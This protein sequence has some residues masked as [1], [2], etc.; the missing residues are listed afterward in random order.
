[1][2]KLTAR[3]YDGQTSAQQLVEVIFDDTGKVRVSG[4]SID[5]YYEIAEVNSLPRIGRLPP[6]LVF[7]D[8]VVCELDDH[9]Q[10]EAALRRL[11]RRSWQ[12]VIHRIENN[13]WAILL[14]LVLAVFIMLAVI[15]YGIPLGAKSVAYQIP[16]EMEQHMGEEALAVFDK[17]LCKPSKLDEATRRRL[18]TRFM[19]AVA[20]M[21]APR[22]QLEFRDCGNMGAN[23]FALPSGIIVFTDAMVKL[24]KNDR[25]LIGVLAHEVGHVENRHIMRQ[26]LQNSVTGLLLV[27]L[28]G[29]IGSASSLAAAVPTLLVQAKFSRAFETEA[30]DYAARFLQSQGIPPRQ[31]ANLLQRLAEQSGEQESSVSGFLSSHPLTEDRIRKL[32]SWNTPGSH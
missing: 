1:M 32:D 22:I 11:P 5:A 2:I 15:Q 14:T 10:L 13:L 30:D 16:L 7:P 24:A 4:E 20:Q 21:H 19:S 17:T 31:L 29:D 28:T 23:A 9:P 25:E 18:E 27:L 6:R 3:R 12:N 8:G 26:V